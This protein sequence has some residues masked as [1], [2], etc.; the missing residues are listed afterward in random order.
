MLAPHPSRI[1]MNL[2]IVQIDQFDLIYLLKTI[3]LR[4]S[5]SNRL[6]TPDDYLQLASLSP[7]KQVW[8]I[9]ESFAPGKYF[10]TQITMQKEK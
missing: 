10:A 1:I 7:A 5:L 3:S 4:H 2:S 9:E 6:S 8:G